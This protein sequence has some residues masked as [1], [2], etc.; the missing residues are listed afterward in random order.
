MGDAIPSIMHQHFLEGDDAIPQEIMEIQQRLRDANQGW[1]YSF[2]N[3]C[4][5]EAIIRLNRVCYS[6]T[7]ELFHPHARCGYR[8]VINEGP[9]QNA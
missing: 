2:W 6:L 8:K 1:Q 7:L 5:A 9:S 3:S 4:R